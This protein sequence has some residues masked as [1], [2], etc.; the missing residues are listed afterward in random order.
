MA[1]QTRQKSTSKTG[2]ASLEFD[3][4]E[5]NSTMQEFLKEE[6]KE[7]GK[8]I[9]NAATISGMVMLFLAISFL[10]QW[11]GLPIGD[12]FAK[13][14]SDAIGGLPIVGGALVTLVG[15]GFL[16]GDRKRARKIKKAKKKAQK[17]ARVTQAQSASYSD[18][19]GGET[20]GFES[21][22]S[23][24]RNDLDSGATSS[25]EDSSFTDF[26]DYGYR[27]SRKLMRSRSD[28]KWTGVCGGLAKYFG[29]S[30]TVVRFI[31]VAAFFMGYGTSLL[32]YFGLS[33]AMP[34]EPIEMMDDF[35]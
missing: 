12:N 11:V 13:F 17:Q 4:F 24:L 29:I 19:P 15:F 5:L 2:T 8:S 22:S 28:K 30:S 20:S 9:W 16:V 7:T 32:I 18:I 1:E 33:L 26:N 21:S 25:S 3:E 31:F 6:D 27:H 10:I 34:K 23:R 35:E 14:V